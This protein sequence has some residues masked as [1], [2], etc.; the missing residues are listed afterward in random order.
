MLAQGWL[1]Q[2]QADE[3]FGPGDTTEQA[4]AGP[5][6]EVSKRANS[7]KWEEVYPAAR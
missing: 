6:A 1:T 7:P 3:W 2:E 4:E 5:P